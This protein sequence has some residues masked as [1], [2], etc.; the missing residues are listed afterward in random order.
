MGW[1]NWGDFLETFDTCDDTIS[2]P[3]SLVHVNMP[4]VLSPLLGQ[5]TAQLLY[6]IREEATV[7][8]F[9]AI[10]LC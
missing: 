9:P 5:A 3:V 7:M 10:L 6:L 4:I 8:V 2:N 1:G